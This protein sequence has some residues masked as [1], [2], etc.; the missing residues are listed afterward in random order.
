M[1]LKRDESFSFLFFCLMLVKLVTLK[2][3]D[4]DCDQ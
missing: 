4:F 2:R 3:V 1:R